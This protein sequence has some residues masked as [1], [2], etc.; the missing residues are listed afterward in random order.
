M[1]DKELLEI[2]ACPV[3]KSDV[4]DINEKVICF[5]C[6]RQYPIRK[7]IPIMLEKEASPKSED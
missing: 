5:A 6:K 7:G 3:C 4:K 1:I 2:L